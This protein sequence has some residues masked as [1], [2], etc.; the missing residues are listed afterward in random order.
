VPGA[1]FVR[2]DLSSLRQTHDL[3]ADLSSQHPVIDALVL[4]AFRFNPSRVQTPE[5]LEHTFALYVLSRRI[6]ADGL[7]GS[8]AAAP[9]PVIVNLCGVGGIRAGRIQW[10]N[11]QLTRGYRGFTA[12]MQATRGNELLG[13]SFAQRHGPTGVRY[14][15]HNPLFVATGLHKPFKQPLRAIVGVTSAIFAQPVAKAVQPI[16]ERIDRP[17]DRPLSAF[18]RATPI[19]LTVDPAA[20]QRFDETVGAIIG[21]S[22]STAQPDG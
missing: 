16:A 20:A 6:L 12:T 19:D 14:V 1:R 10:D 7:L 2:A 13:A 15:L 3:V 9:A 5:G 8:L 22:S 18:R 11:L 4:G 17:P 21:I